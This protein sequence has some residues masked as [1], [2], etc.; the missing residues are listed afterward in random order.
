MV[1]ARYGDAITPEDAELLG[2]SIQL[3]FSGRVV[4]SRLLKG[5]IYVLSVLYLAGT[6]AIA[7]TIS[8]ER[9][10]GILAFSRYIQARSSF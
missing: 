7:S 10:L 6:H 1:L 8:S 5:G 2:Q 9:A 4:K 3:P